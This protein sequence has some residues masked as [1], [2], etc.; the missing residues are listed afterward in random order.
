ML[1]IT[2]LM[3][4]VVPAMP[5]W[6]N[7]LQSPPGRPSLKLPGNGVATSSSSVPAVH[8]GE[9]AIVYFP[10]CIS[11]TMGTY[12]GQKRNL[13][14]T[15]MSI[16]KKAGVRVSMLDNAMGSCC[17]QIF[18][19]KGFK[20]AHR[21]TANSIVDKLW[22]SSKE[23]SLPIVVDVSS[24][25]YTLHQIRP[26]LDEV[27]RKK[28]DA[29]KIMDSVEFLHEMVVP[30]IE[31]KRKEKS[32]VLHPVCSL[33]KMKTENQFLQ[34]AS[35]FAKEVT[36]PKN[37]GCCGMAGDRGFLFPELTASAT[38]SEAAEVRAVAYDG[39]YST[40][41]TCELAMSESVQQNYESILYLVDEAV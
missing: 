34:I 7:Y 10:A 20:E 25:A 18:S 38:A 2:R 28:Y 13:M 14:E 1:N 31:V 36:I 5:L 22:A 33:K 27:R 37:A 11:R 17:G 9:R 21:H 30:Y 35:H 23:G 29:L 16:C 32:I 4:K 12:Q 19:S 15:F 39:Y 40:T 24:C 26:A 3:K 41:K 8:A 6:S